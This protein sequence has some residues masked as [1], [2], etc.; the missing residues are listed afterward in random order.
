MSDDARWASENETCLNPW[1][2]RPD[3]RID[4]RL[5]RNEAAWLL[6]AV[7]AARHG[8]AISRTEC[9]ALTGLLEQALKA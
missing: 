4:V 5:T 9:A 8:S 2:D 6:H 3:E 7:A 1:I